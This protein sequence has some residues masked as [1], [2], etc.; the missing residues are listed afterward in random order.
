M[1]GRGGGGKRGLPNREGVGEVRG[2]REGVW[3]YVGVAK[4]E[5]GLAKAEACGSRGTRGSPSE[6]VGEG[7]KRAMVWLI[8]TDYIVAVIGLAR[9]SA[10]HY[11]LLPWHKTSLLTIVSDPE[12]TSPINPSQRRR[13]T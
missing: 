4:S 11:V 8:I 12:P 6:G 10:G 1:G 3:G 5:R 13:R 9:A 7:Q 2:A